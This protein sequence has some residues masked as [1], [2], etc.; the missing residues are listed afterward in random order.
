MKT[1]LLIGL[2]PKTLA[3]AAAATLSATIAD[4]QRQFAARGDHLDLCVIKLDGSAEAPVT[5]QLA[6][7]TYDCAFIGGGLREPDA[8]LELLERIVNA[9]HHQAP[10]TAIG[11]VLE[12]DG[13]L[14]AADRVLSPAYERAGL[15]ASFAMVG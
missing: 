1:F 14:K 8:H 15:R 5:A 4:M 9:L 7:D 3:D 6:R 10:G 2:D 13:C 12:P 11:F